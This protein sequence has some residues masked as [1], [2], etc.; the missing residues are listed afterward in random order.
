[1]LNSPLK[2]IEVRRPS[3]VAPTRTRMTEGC[4]FVVDAIDSGRVY[5][6]RTGRPSDH[7]ASAR[8]GCTERSSLLPKPPPTAVGVMRT[9][10]SGSPRI[11]SSSTRSM[12][13]DCVVTCTST[14]SPTRR[15]KPAS[16]S[17]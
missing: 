3:R 4:R 2:S 13:G 14:R 5:V 17:M 12:C 15:A 6:S 8:Y 7:A 11:A 9:A 16:G 10:P 1:M